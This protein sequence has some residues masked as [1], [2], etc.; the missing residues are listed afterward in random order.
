MT[1]E[2]GP[3]RNLREN[4]LVTQLI[5]QGAEKLVKD[6]V[7]ETPEEAEALF[8]EVKRYIAIAAHRCVSMNAGIN[9][10]SS[11]GNTSSSAGNISAGTFRTARATPGNRRVQSRTA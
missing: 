5:A 11:R 6:R 1:E 2:R 10:F 8:T 4:P 7:V 9:S 3:D